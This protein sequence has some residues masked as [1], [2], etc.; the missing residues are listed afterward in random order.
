MMLKQV[1]SILLSFLLLISSVSGAVKI[2]YCDGQFM[3]VS[4]L[5]SGGTCCCNKADEEKDCCD[6]ELLF[7][8]NEQQ[9]QFFQITDV[10]EDVA[11]ANIP[12]H[13]EE[14]VLAVA[15]VQERLDLTDYLPPPKSALWLLNCSLVLYS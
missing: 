3:T 1:I 13:Q 4:I 14:L 2:H 10:L 15:K 5:P 8:D 6:D 7:I 11:F 12:Q 9:A